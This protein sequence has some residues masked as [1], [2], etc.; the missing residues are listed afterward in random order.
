MYNL[1]KTY[2]KAI[3]LYL[4][5]HI[6]YIKNVSKKGEK[7]NLFF[8]NNKIKKKQTF[9]LMLEQKKYYLISI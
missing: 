8:L 2:L 4:I 9:A 5:R 6:N 7:F 1:N 3:N